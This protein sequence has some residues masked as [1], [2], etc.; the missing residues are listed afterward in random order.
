MVIGE[1]IANKPGYYSITYVG[2]DHS[3]NRTEPIVRVVQVIPSPGNGIPLTALSKRVSNNTITISRL[4]SHHI[5]L[6]WTGEHELLVSGSSSG[7]YLPTGVKQGPYLI[8]H[9][10]SLAEGVQFFKLR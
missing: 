1:V 10:D 5:V 9:E 8:N 3:G 7:P 4:D 2:V 6:D